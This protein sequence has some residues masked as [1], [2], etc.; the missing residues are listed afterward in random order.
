VVVSSKTK[1]HTGG[2]IQDRLKQTQAVS[3]GPDEDAI[4]AVEPRMYERNNHRP[5]V[6]TYVTPNLTQL[7]EGGKTSRND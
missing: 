3:G 1:R 2:G 7:L 5:A 6:V 4:S